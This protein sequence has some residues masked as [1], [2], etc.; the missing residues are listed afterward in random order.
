VAPQTRQLATAINRSISAKV[1]ERRFA[2]GD[3]GK[4]PEEMCQKQKQTKH[5]QAI[6]SALE[7]Q[8]KKL[9]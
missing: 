4:K 7:K 9:P 8:P 2:V 3:S 1:D 5:N 6:K